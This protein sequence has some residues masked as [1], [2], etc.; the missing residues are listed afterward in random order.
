MSINS[1]AG[2]IAAKALTDGAPGG[3][4]GQLQFNNS[5]IFGGISAFS[6]DG[7]KL[8]LTARMEMSIGSGG[9]NVSIGTS[10]GAA[11]TSGIGNIC[12]GSSS[13]AANTTG[14]YNVAIGF[15]ALQYDVTSSSSVAIGVLAI[16]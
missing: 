5:G 11:L 13:G 2:G 10:A 12:I 6:W 14:S 7:T 1:T 3:S 15:G 9:G 8:S 4:S 16:I